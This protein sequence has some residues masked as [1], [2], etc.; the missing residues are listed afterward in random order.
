MNMQLKTKVF[1]LSNGKY[2]KLSDL[3]Q[4]MGVSL[5]QVYRV[6]RGKS[7]IGEKFIIGALRASPG[8]SSMTCFML[9]Q[10]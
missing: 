1:E 7:D 10:T 6:R 3:A 9:F 8:I 4:A 5:T 2:A